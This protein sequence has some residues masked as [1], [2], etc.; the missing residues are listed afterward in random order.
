MNESPK[1]SLPAPTVAHGHLEVLIVHWH[2]ESTSCGE[3]QDAA[4]VRAAGV[5]WMHDGS[6]E[7]HPGM[8]ACWKFSPDRTA[9]AGQR[10]YPMPL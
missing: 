3:G 8:A 10:T 4:D 1:G 5:T 2:A 6:Y 9:A 7:W